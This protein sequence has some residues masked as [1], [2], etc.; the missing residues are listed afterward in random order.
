MDVGNAAILQQPEIF[1]A[2]R[3]RGVIAIEVEAAAG[4]TRRTTV[5]EE[6]SLRVRFPGPV[7]PALQA[8]IVNT[9]GG[10]AGGDRYDIACHA[11]AGANLTVSTAAAEKVYR[12]MGM[13]AEVSIKLIAEAGA[14][15]AW[16]PQE[17][18]FFDNARLSRRIDV[19][20]AED[21]SVLMTEAIVFGRSAMGEA[22]RTG[23]FTDRWRVQRGGRLVF[24]ETVRLDGEIAARLA[25]PAVTGG[26]IA[27]ATV[28]IAPGS[29]AQVEAIRAKGDQFRGEVGASAWNG[30]A[31][32]RLCAPDG[33]A[34]RHDLVAVLGALGREILPRLWSM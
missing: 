11:G 27:L 8:V 19:T 2:N 30:F 3:A 34:L 13:D 26:N 25:E 17:T 14:A 32:A 15:L 21:A 5:R 22:V 12:S 7:A 18:I 29:D 28:L 1:A 31:L 4:V 9:A 23:S 24:A 10:T 33:A 20:L 6:G 16:L